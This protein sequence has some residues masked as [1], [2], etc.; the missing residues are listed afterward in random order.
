MKTILRSIVAL[1][2]IATLATGNMGAA[3]TPK[4]P[5]VPNQYSA[6][7]ISAIP[8][9]GKLTGKENTTKR[10]Q[11]VVSEEMRAKTALARK[12][13]TELYTVKVV[14][15]GEQEMPY[16]AIYNEGFF[17][18]TSYEVWSG[19]ADPKTYYFNVPAGTYDICTNGW[20]NLDGS[21]EYVLGTLVRE[22][23]VVDKD[24]E[25]T[26]SQTE[27]TEQAQIRPR[28]R[29]G[30]YVEI[31]SGYYTEE[32][33]FI[34]DESK[35][36]A[37]GVSHV[38]AFFKEGCE[39][40]MMGFSVAEFYNSETAERFSE[41]YLYNKVS[42][43]YHFVSA[44]FVS[45]KEG[46]TE[47]SVTDLREFKTG[48]YT[49]Y[50]DGFVEYPFPEFAHTPLYTDTSI[51]KYNTNVKGSVWLNNVLFGSGSAMLESESPKVFC[52]VQPTTS[53][54]LDLKGVITAASL[55]V[56]STYIEIIDIGDGNIWEEEIRIQCGIISLPAYYNG[57][58][59]EY[60]NQNHSECGNFSFQ[61]PADGGE[62]V[63]Y[64]G[65]AAYSFCED[66]I[67]APFG[68]SAPILAHM[69][70]KVPI[71]ETETALY[72]TPNAYIGRYGELR[73]SDQMNLKSEVYLSGEKIFEGS[74]IILDNWIWEF[75]FD[76][77]EKGELELVYTN[78]NVRVDDV[79]GFNITKV[80]VD[81]RNQ[82]CFA[83]TTQMLIFK[84]DKGVI[85]DRFDKAENGVIEFSA[86]DFNFTT[87]NNSSFYTCAP[88][89]VKVEYAPYGTTNFAE[90][91]VVE[92]PENYYMPGFGYF[93]RGSLADVNV[94]S[95]NGWFDL[96]FTLTDE[97]GNSMEQRV[98]PAFHINELASVERVVKEN[99]VTFL[100]T[101]NA[102]HAVGA[103]IAGIELY[104]VD[105]RKIAS[106]AGSTV[107]TMGYKGVVIA[108]A[109]DVSGAS[110]VAR[111]YVK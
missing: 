84:D 37:T 14:F 73:Q 92:V 12:N 6:G 110:S 99:N 97:A 30:E 101:N 54:N 18:E 55:D 111:L 85:T 45:A 25:E 56:D 35:A 13:A 78:N 1:I 10:M 88:L 29:N 41:K 83:P 82:D 27:L 7:R 74:A 77:H 63:E 3:T 53:E 22:N 102:V 4:N 51:E 67:T 32:G 5:K 49:N 87:E 90:L 93:Y 91:N 20:F 89:T 46:D 21:N 72:F 94:P 28:L 17:E 98:S 95:E 42:D 80:K 106:S 52:S 47:Y 9:K 79:D 76:G 105:G 48:E 40:V 66:E 16:I 62:I 43:D 109:T 57:E 100:T 86:G 81:E 33:E 2:A 64:P 38:Y 39:S 15:D 107:S 103:D 69:I 8:A 11:A 104:A 26:L 19:L 96:R 61:I 36:N 44:W 34:L 108:R 23:I 58:K 75:A 59:W 68:N 31:P 70:Q 65:V 24:V 50:I 71:S 60:V